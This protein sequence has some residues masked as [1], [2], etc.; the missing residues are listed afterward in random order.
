MFLILVLFIVT[1]FSTI[2]CVNFQGL[3]FWCRYVPMFG[4][5]DYDPSCSYSAVSIEEQLQALS[6]AVKE[7]KVIFH[8]IFGMFSAFASLL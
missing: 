2:N 6:V 7:G 8:P 4:D 5:T 1:I 3:F